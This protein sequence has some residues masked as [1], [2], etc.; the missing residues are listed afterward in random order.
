MNDKKISKGL[1]KL[2]KSFYRAGMGN[3]V[4]E[5]KDGVLLLTGRVKSVKERVNAGYT[6]AGFAGK[7]GLRGTVNDLA[8]DGLEE[9]GDETPF[10]QG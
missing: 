3:I 7:Y 10:F 5:I 1:K 4:P 2:V 8:V 9:P 6:G